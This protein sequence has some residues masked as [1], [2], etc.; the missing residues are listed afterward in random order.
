MTPVGIVFDIKKYAIHDGPGIRTTVFLKGCPL[1]CWWCH[2]PESFTQAPQTIVHSAHSSDL[3]VPRTEVIGRKMSVSEV[4]IEINKDQIFYDQSGGGIT[5]SGGEPL[6]QFDFLDALLTACQREEYSIALDTSGYAPREHFEQI[7]SKIDLFLYD[8]KVLD[9]EHHRKFTGVS[10]TRILSNLRYLIQ[11]QANVLIR[12]PIIPSITATSK[13]IRDLGNYLTTLPSI[14]PIELLPFHKI[15]EEKY[16]QLGLKNKMKEINPPT[17]RNLEEIKQQ[18]I[19]LGLV[20][21]SNA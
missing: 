4:M 12:F 15:G 10:N 20:I 3:P 9:N 5:F 21:Y 13:N 8:L 19:S 6:M 2:N 14:P 7:I 11:Q 1:R 16:E 17:K 18:L